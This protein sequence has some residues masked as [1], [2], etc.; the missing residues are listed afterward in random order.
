MLFKETT[1]NDTLSI[2]HRVV[3][4]YYVTM[5]ANMMIVVLGRTG[6]GGHVALP[7][8]CKLMLLLI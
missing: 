2:H 6:Y 3:I 4:W 8:D 7:F 5:R 1:Y